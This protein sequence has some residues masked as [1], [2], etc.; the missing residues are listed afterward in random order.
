MLSIQLAVI[1]AAVGSIAR[2]VHRNSDI[3]VRLYP[4]TDDQPSGAGCR[5][6]I[7]GKFESMV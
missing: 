2:L 4:M 6:A 5:S 3:P 7:S 1:I